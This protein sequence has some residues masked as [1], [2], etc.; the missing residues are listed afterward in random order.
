VESRGRGVCESLCWQRV[1][2]RQRKGHGEKENTHEEKAA[3]MREE[4]TNLKGPG[5]P[6]KR[7]AALS[8]GAE[9][10]KKKKNVAGRCREGD[11]TVLGQFGSMAKGA[12]RKECLEEERRV[13]PKRKES[14]D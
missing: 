8:P 12:L 7:A 6:D 4:A 1:H 9:V 2:L 11:I 5:M 10:S 13:R 3:K 14:V